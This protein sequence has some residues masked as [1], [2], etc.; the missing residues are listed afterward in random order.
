MKNNKK[1]QTESSEVTTLSVAQVNNNIN[2]SLNQNDLIELAIEEHLERL[3]GQIS[4]SEK[5]VIS[6]NQEYNNL[7]NNYKEN[8]VNTY[9][10]K[11]TSYKKIMD[12]ATSLIPKAHLEVI[13]TIQYAS[14]S[15]KGNKK[16]GESATLATDREIRSFSQFK[17][18]IYYRTEYHS[19]ATGVSLT[20]EFC[21]SDHTINRG[22]MFED[23]IGTASEI[24]YLN[25]QLDI[26]TKKTISAKKHLLSLQEQY[27][28]YKF[29]DKRIKAKII[30]ESLNKSKEGRDILSMLERAS[31]I[32]LLPKA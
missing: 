29:G 8:L 32:K 17:S 27:Y 23:I 12:V 26:I 22:I 16:L 31:N 28:T 1:N 2:L 3:E 9:L 18:C 14:I 6:L 20:I 24:S 4:D 11:S 21:H 25:N 5:E 13:K 15:G 30:R 10:K 7:K 19:E